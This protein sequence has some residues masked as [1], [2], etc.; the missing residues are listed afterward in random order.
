MGGGRRMAE[1]QGEVIGWKGE[2]RA[3]GGRGAHSTNGQISHIT[4]VFAICS[5]PRSGGGVCNNR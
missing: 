3:E 5:S 1:R 4:R 2:E